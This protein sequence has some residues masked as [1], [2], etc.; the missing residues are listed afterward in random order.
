MNVAVA[1][2]RT[3]A[4]LRD[5]PSRMPW[6]PTADGA[7]V[8]HYASLL[9][10]LPL[11]LYIARRQWFF[12]DEWD[13]LTNRG[14]FPGYQLGLLAP[15]NEHWSTIPIL[16]YRALFAVFA[17]HSYVPYLAVLLVAH[18]ASAHLL[19]RVMLRS[20]ADVWVATA[21]SALFLV[22]GTGYENIL[23]AFQIG[24]VGS[25]ALGLAAVLVVD[26][27]RGRG[28]HLT[29]WLLLVAGLMCSDVG[30]AMVVFAAVVA[31]IRGG[32]RAFVTVASLPAAV[33]ICWFAAY[34]HQGVS[35]GALTAGDF[36]QLPTAVV[37]GLTAAVGGL[38]GVAAL[39]AAGALAALAGVVWQRHALVARPMV[40]AS[41]V[42][43]VAYVAFLGLGRGT[44]EEAAP[45]Q[46]YVVAALLIPAAGLLLTQLAR[47][48][49][50]AHLIAVCLIVFCAAINF[51]QLLIH[52]GG[53]LVANH[54]IDPGGQSRSQILAASVLVQQGAPAIGRSPDVAFAPLLTVTQL[55][56]LE[57][58]GD[59]PPPG[60]LTPTDY[61]SAHATL[62]T[63]FSV[64]RMF[65][66]GVAQ[67]TSTGG[68]LVSHDSSACTALD[69]VAGTPFVVRLS[70][71]A[72]GAVAI[73]ARAA[74]EVQ[75]IITSSDGTQSAHP[76]P[77]TLAA[78]QSVWLNDML[79]GDPAVVTSSGAPLTVCGLAPPGLTSAA[80]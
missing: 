70:F 29:A 61:L 35:S 62:Q 16:V 34:G 36:Q 76:I 64:S 47:R 4:T 77:V 44:G 6:R 52:T 12:L 59:L 58:L 53:G 71:D 63:S 54:E 74:A 55:R 56:R 78:G 40:L 73:I 48:D 24:F 41:A 75:L 33:Y 20:G 8:L 11:L 18:I 7:R 57:S 39:G 13:F 43:A 15:H 38:T 66:T 3:T 49:V 51:G 26:R 37:T 23:W 27:S 69:S 14:G 60:P 45:R 9:V 28:A 17:L 50:A 5:V 21:L 2:P 10:A 72:P 31:G 1:S 46:V 80:S 25:L 22:L 42:A 32:V 79:A 19:W 67:I 68:A 30:I 65:T